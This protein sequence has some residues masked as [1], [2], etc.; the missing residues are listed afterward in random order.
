MMLGGN[1]RWSLLGRKGLIGGGTERWHWTLAYEGVPYFRFTSRGVMV[2]P[3]TPQANVSKSHLDYATGV[4]VSCSLLDR[5][6]AFFMPPSNWYVRPT[7]QRHLLIWLRDRL[8]LL[9]LLLLLWLS[10]LLLSVELR[11]GND[12]AFNVIL[13]LFLFRTSS[14]SLTARLKRKAKREGFS[15]LRKSLFL[16]NL[17]QE[18]AD[19]QHTDMYIA[20]R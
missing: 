17:W 9:L 18:K 8:L 16:V 15:Y 7:A 14:L 1:W 6:L 3:H 13:P 2:S 11:Y 5:F 10:L 20:W 4:Y 19:F 12:A